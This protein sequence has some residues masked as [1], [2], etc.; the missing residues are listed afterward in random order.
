MYHSYINNRYILGR[1]HYSYSYFF[2]EVFV[3]PS[4][5]FLFVFR[6]RLVLCKLTSR[7]LGCHLLAFSLLWL[8]FFSPLWL[9]EKLLWETSVVTAKQWLFP[10]SVP[11]LAFPS[12]L[13]IPYNPAFSGRAT[14]SVASLSSFYLV[15]SV[16]HLMEINPYSWQ[17]YAIIS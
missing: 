3:V 11:I 12:S 7:R 1:G 14:V 17:E 15:P 13:L 2:N 16:L 10:T 6:G 5:L 4:S 8:F 9:P